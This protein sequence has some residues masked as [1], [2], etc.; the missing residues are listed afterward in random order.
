MKTTSI[1]AKFG[2][3]DETKQGVEDISYWVYVNDNEMHAI[4]YLGTPYCSAW[5]YV[6]NPST[7]ITTI[8]S[9]LIENV[10]PDEASAS[11]FYDNNFGSIVFDEDESKLAV[12]RNFYAIGYNHPT[13]GTTPNSQRN[14]HVHFWSATYETGTYEYYG[15]NYYIRM[16]LG[17]AFGS[18]YGHP[19][20]CFAVRLFRDN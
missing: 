2:Y 4:R 3:N 6:W 13:E 18:V 7:H 17:W 20:T 11:S 15:K 9:T 12:K 5:K 16:S 10:G 1:V 14:V 8:Y 19:E